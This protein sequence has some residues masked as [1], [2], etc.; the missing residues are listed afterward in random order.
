MKEEFINSDMAMVGAAAFN[1]VIQTVQ[2]S[3]LNY[4]L[5]LTPFSA[6]ISL[7]NTVVKDRFGSPVINGLENVAIEEELQKLHEKHN[8]TMKKYEAAKDTIA[9]LQTMLHDREEAYKELE[10]RYNSASQSAVVLNKIINENRVKYEEEKL[11]LFKDHKNEIKSWKK[12]LGKA[13]KKHIKLEKKFEAL[14]LI[15]N[16][17]PDQQNETIKDDTSR[18]LSLAE[19]PQTSSKASTILCSMCSDPI[20]QYVPEYFMGE[21]FNPACRR[22]KNEPPDPYSSFPISGPPSTLMSHW[23]PPHYEASTSLLFSPSFRSHY[24]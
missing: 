18:T 10:S 5:Q 21:K 17:V 13:N 14:L 1:N 20:L 7:K 24:V 2:R 8:Q 3:C 16:T 22:C 6:V 15:N 12:D 4:H 11:M 9:N 23:I 19:E